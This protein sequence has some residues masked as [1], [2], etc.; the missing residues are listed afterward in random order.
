[1]VNV[2]QN[3]RKFG[4]HGTRTATTS[5]RCEKVEKWKQQVVTSSD[6]RIAIRSSDRHQIIITSSHHVPLKTSETLMVRQESDS[7]VYRRFFRWQHTDDLDKSAQQSQRNTHRWF[8][9]IRAAGNWKLFVTL[10]SVHKFKF[11]AV[12]VL[13][14]EE[15]A[16][17]IL[18]NQLECGSIKVDGNHLSSQNIQHLWDIFT[19][20]PAFKS[21]NF[22][23]DGQ[24]LTL[25][26][27]S[28]SM[29][30]SLGFWMGHSN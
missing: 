28:S 18:T 7:N 11:V 13:S 19:G 5:S 23:H 16:E 30:H 3:L 27:L 29:R 26:T 17:T 20:H 24:I 15:G 6:H 9:Q 4:W 25:S 8:R 10:T 21:D 22:L 14:T 2:G 1:M 12:A